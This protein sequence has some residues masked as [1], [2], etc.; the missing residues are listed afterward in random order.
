MLMNAVDD[1]T[2]NYLHLSVK[3]LIG[4]IRF[5]FNS[6]FARQGFHVIFKGLVLSMFM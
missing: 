2:Y 1:Y 3:F 5:T 6:I 4:F